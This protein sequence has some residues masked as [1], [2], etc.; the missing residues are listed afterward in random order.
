MT[1]LE[2]S[3]QGAATLIVYVGAALVSNATQSGSIIFIALL[4][5]S[6]FFL[7]ICN[8]RTKY[9]H[10]HGHVIKRKQGV[11]V[12]KR[13]LDLANELIKETG[14]DDWALAL[15]MINAKNPKSLHQGGKVIL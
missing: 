9:L 14:R 1:F 8:H 15:G 5:V 2:N 13:R 4:L 3:L 6:V 7:A 10:M 11:K 12:Y